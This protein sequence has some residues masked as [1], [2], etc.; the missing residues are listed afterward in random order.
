ME[1]TRSIERLS[2]DKTLIIIAHRLSTVAK[3]DCIYF[4]KE[5]KVHDSGTFDHFIQHNSEFQKMA[6][7][8]PNPR[9]STTWPHEDLEQKF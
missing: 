6:G 1:I 8:M 3:C 9:G 7:I 5:G 4:M 2:Q